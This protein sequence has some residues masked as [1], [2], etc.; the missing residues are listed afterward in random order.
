VISDQRSGVPGSQFSVLRFRWTTENRKQGTVRLITDHRSP[1][2]DYVTWLLAAVLSASACRFVAV[3]L[4]PIDQALPLIALIVMFLA[5]N[6]NDTR[7]TTAVPLLM[8]V[9]I[10]VGDERARLLVIGVVVASAFAATT[11]LAARE[12]PIPLR[13]AAVIVTCAVVLLRWIP[14]QNVVVWRE[15]F[16]LAGMFA[17]VMRSRARAPLGLAAAVALA[18][19]IPARPARMLLTPF[20]AAILP[21]P[22]AILFV[23]P[24]FFVRPPLAEICVATAFA[25]AAPLLRSRIVA[26]PL[27]SA[28]AL[29]LMLFPWS[30]VV[31]RGP[32]FFFHRPN[33]ASREWVGFAFA[34]SESAT[35]DLPP[36][37]SKLI[38]SGANAATLPRGTRLGMVGTTSVQVGDIA[39]WGYMRA[40]QWF[41]SRNVVPREPAGTIHDYGFS[42]WADGAGA[43]AIPPGKKSI[44][45]TADPRLPPKT[46]LQVESIESESQ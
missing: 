8:V 36:H 40:A 27:L 15:L 42:A 4:T 9:E 29:A 30:G 18:L 16:L 3:G 25:L 13:Q 32:A 1:I 20:L 10:A 14:F 46:R 17:V 2:T 21:A 24:A 37:A 6:V 26:T 39:D 41:G 38:L 43:V 23:I 31:S 5:W 19:V 45:I 12:G 33:A 7:V 34:P 22:F 44:R 35:I 11:A 28:A